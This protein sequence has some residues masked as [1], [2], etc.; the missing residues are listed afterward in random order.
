[1]QKTTLVKDKEIV[2]SWHQIDASQFTLG[3]L[4]S[5][6]AHLLS[7]KHKTT[8]SRHQDQGDFVVVVNVGKIKLSTPVK[9]ATAKT[10]FRYSGYSG[11]LKKESL[12]VKFKKDPEGVVRHAVQGMLDSNRLRKLKL[13]RLKIVEGSEHKY[14]VNHKS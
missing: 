8:Y 14:P 5:Q 4:A 7:G 9:K 3:R 11:G 13:R 12:E 2:R 10:Y 6:V 1:M